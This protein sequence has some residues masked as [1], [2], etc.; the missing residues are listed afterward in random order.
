MSGGS[1]SRTSFF[2]SCFMLSL[3][4]GGLTD[5]SEKK[6]MFESMVYAMFSSKNIM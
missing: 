6:Y 1:Q 3:G 2:S 4:G 5:E